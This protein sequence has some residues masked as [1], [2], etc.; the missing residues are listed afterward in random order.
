M[1]LKVIARPNAY[2]FG[3]DW[4]LRVSKG[5]KVKTFY[6]GQDA[7]VCKRVIGLDMS[8]FGT[9]IREKFKTDLIDFENKKINEFI[10]QIILLASYG[11]DFSTD[12]DLNETIEECIGNNIFEKETWELSSQ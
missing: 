1:K 12:D 10:G 3:K 2:G 11:I 7:K 5:K 8:S 4:L 6:L 9:I